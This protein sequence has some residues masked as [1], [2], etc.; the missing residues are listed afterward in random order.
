[1][2]N[3]LLSRTGLVEDKLKAMEVQTLRYM[4]GRWCGDPFQILVTR[5]G[6]VEGKLR[7]T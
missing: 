4:H 2:L 1:M 3:D 5:A 7:G 6:I